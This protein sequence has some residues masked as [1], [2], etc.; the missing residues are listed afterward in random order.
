LAAAV[1]LSITHE[2]P[3]N[4]GIRAVILIKRSLQWAS[5]ATPAERV[6]VLWAF[7]YFF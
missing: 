7:A 2:F 5:P 4:A 1:I 6:V 3:T